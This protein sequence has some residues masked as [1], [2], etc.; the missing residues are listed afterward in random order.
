MKNIYVFLIHLGYWFLLLFLFF[1]IYLVSRVN[2]NGGPAYP[3]LIS[4]LVGFILIPSLLSFYGSYFYLFHLYVNKSDKIRLILFSTSLIILSTVISL[5]SIYKLIKTPQVFIEIGI[6]GICL[7]VFNALIGFILHSFVSW[8]TDL[9][10]KDELHKKNKWLELEMIKLKLDPHFLFNTINNIDVLIESD[11]VKASEYMIKLSS[12]LRFYL[13]QSSSETIQLKDELMYIQD[14]IE[15]QKIRTNN[16]DYVHLLVHG[17]A[18]EKEIPPMILIPFIE[19]AFKHSTNKKTANINIEITIL[20]SKLLFN[21]TNTFDPNRKTI[22]GIGNTLIEN[23]LKL[24]YGTNY[25]ME[26]STV[27][28]KYDLKLTL[29]L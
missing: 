2:S 11:S 20:D 23:R 26:V 15:L 3:Y 28:D 19:N 24:L 16:V 8:F 12:L 17:N 29:P 6:V 10:V 21:C 4:I 9:K 7:N 27:N 13:Y 25:T 1:I 14:Y 18:G 22:E 5:F